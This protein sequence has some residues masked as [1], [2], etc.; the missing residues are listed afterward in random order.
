[1]AMVHVRKAKY[2]DSPAIARI[3]VDSYRTAYVAY[4]PESYLEHFTYEEETQDWQQ[5]LTSGTDDLLFVAENEMGEIAG[6]ALGRRN[7][8]ETKPFDGTLVAM[9]VRQEEQQKGFGRALFAAVA[10]ALQAQGC[11]S[12]WLSTLPGN[13]AHAWYERLGGEQFDETEYHVDGSEIV[14]I[15][16]GWDTIQRLQQMLK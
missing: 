10:K 9:H 16:Y 4:F 3:Q 12:L 11:T 5:L 2:R 15:C 6:Y 8:D 1:M 7:T 13:P 14:E